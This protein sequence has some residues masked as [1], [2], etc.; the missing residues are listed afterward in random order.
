MIKNTLGKGLSIF[1]LLAVFVLSGA[2]NKDV[3]KVLDDKGSA[4]NIRTPAWVQAY[5]AGGNA[6]VEKLEQ[7]KEKYCFVVLVSDTNKDY[8]VSSAHDMSKVRNEIQ[9]AS[10]AGARIEADWWQ[11][12]KHKKTTLYRAF[13]LWV[14]EK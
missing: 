9:N 5:L 4:L 2:S 1:M 13:T 11:L 10:F 3:F 8:A 14:R 7:Y 6:A 12:V